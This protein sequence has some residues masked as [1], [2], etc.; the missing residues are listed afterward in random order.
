MM[1]D[2][3]VV[4]GLAFL[5]VFSTISNAANADPIKVENQITKVS[6]S[7][8]SKEQILEKYKD[9]VSLNPHECKELL[10]AVGFEGKALRMAWAVAQK[11]SNCR[12]KAWN[13]NRK[14]GD[15]SFG[16]FQINMI[17]ELGPARLEKFNLDSNKDLL[18]PVTSAQIAFYMSNEGVD[19]SSWTHLDKERFKSFWLEYPSLKNK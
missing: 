13:N 16:I 10:S 9:A 2:N 5:L 8:L 4:G 3:L 6:T 12:P 14:T 11:E 7:Q 17:G 15:N 19:W 1:K 18:D